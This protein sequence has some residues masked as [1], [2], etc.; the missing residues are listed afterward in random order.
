MQLGCRFVFRGCAW[1]RMIALGTLAVWIALAGD[2]ARATPIGYASSGGT[3][4][5]NSSFTMGVQFETNQIIFIDS[6]GVLDVGGDG[7]DN[8]HEVGLWDAV[9]N[10]IAS[11]TVLAGTGSTLQDGFRFEAITPVEL[12]A[13]ETFI[14]AAYYADGE[15]GDKLR[16]TTRTANP[17]I[18]LEPVIRFAGGGSLTFPAGTIDDAF[19]STANFTVVPEPTTVLL[20]V[21]GLAALALAGRRTGRSSA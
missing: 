2:S 6:L 15:T 20:L 16:D 18:T 9:G 3:S 14:V 10:Q 8:A 12:A 11:V 7:L 19:S 17:A 5:S 21:A 4:G 1:G 13:G